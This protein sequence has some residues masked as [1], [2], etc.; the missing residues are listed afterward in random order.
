MQVKTM[1]FPSVRVQ[2][3]GRMCVDSADSTLSG[4]DGRGGRRQAGSGADRDKSHKRKS[5]LNRSTTSEVLPP[6]PDTLAPA[7]PSD[8]NGEC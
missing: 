3:E 1:L 4:S 7:L 5:N 2:A 6:A 8:S